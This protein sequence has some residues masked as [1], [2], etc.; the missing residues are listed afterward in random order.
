MKAYL[1]CVE[2]FMGFASHQVEAQTED[3]AWSKITEWA[4]SRGDTILSTLEMWEV[5]EE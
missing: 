2:L 4:E 5:V 1:G 3:E